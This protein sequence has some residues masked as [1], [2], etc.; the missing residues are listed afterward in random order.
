MGPC[1]APG[2]GT[3]A[4]IRP[5]DW[6]T[7]PPGTT[8]L[9]PPGVNNPAKKQTFHA[10]TVRRYLNGSDAE[11]LAALLLLLFVLALLFER[12]TGLLRRHL[13]GRLVSHVYPLSGQQPTP[14]RL[15]AP[16]TAGDER[17]AAP[18]ARSRWA[19]AL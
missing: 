13:A 12:L 16:G 7:G 4:A 9:A 10:G 3:T 18:G 6:R 1:P 19:N 5:S 11:A 2:D 17:G 14:I 8:E 15:A